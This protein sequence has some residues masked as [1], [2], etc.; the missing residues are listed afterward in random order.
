MDCNQQWIN[1]ATRNKEITHL[2]VCLWGVDEP[3]AALS[4]L[5]NIEYSITPKC[6][7]HMYSW[8]YET[9]K[10]EEVKSNQRDT[11][12]MTR[13]CLSCNSNQIVNIQ[14]RAWGRATD[15][16]VLVQITCSVCD[17]LIT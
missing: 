16:G 1:Y 7:P 17:K 5:E 12:S 6:H 4:H 2:V 11:K 13:F 8:I 14:H 9:I 10:L 3:R 15:E